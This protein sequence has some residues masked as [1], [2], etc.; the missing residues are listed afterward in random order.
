MKNGQATPVYISVSPYIYKLRLIERDHPKIN[1]KQTGWRCCSIL[2]KCSG[3][4]H[5]DTFF[6]LERGLT[7]GRWPR[8]STSQWPPV[9][10]SPSKV[11]AFLSQTIG[12]P[13]R[14][15]KSEQRLARNSVSS[16]AHWGLCHT[17]FNVTRFKLLFRNMWLRMTLT[18]HSTKEKWS[19]NWICCFEFLFIIT[20]SKKIPVYLFYCFFICPLCFN[21][22]PTSDRSA[23]LWFWSFLTIHD[24]DCFEGKETIKS[25]MAQIR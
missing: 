11:F 25:L 16:S 21:V 13:S 7:T 15:G 12:L 24:H 6:P 18:S 5:F 1:G 23:N 22:N 20:V 17:Q 2:K 14:D 3:N 10:R 8:N 19:L 9:H 4:L